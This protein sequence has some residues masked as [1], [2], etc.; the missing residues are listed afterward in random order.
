[1][2]RGQVRWVVGVDG[3]KTRPGVVITR[4]AV[5][6]RLRSVLVVP[7]TTT[8]R[9]LPSEV[10]LGP[11]HGLPKAC[12][13]SLDNLSLVDADLLGDVISVL[14]APTMAA[15]CEALAVAVECGS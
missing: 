4:D 2:R 10:P 1:M 14:D 11:E 15:V 12:V 9:G 13:A 6:D 5:A 7:L 3:R 8:V